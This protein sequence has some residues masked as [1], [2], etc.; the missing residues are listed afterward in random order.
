MHPGMGYYLEM[1]PYYRALPEEKLRQSPALMQAMSILCA[2]GMD[3]QGSERWYETLRDFAA[4]S[5]GGDAR[6]AK[7]RL[8]WLDVA[9]PQRGVESLVELFPKIFALLTA[10]EIRLPPFSVTSTLPSLMNGG[11]DFSPWSKRDS[12]L[13]ATLRLPVEA[14]LG[15]DGVGLADCAMAE[16]RFEKGEDIRDR[17][18]K[19]LADLERIR[20]DGTPDMEFAVVGLLAR[21]QMD[22]GHTQDAEESLH[23]LRR[24]LVQAKE[25][26]FL[27]NLDA[28][29][30]RVQLLQADDEAAAVWYRDK[31]PRDPQCIQTLNRY[32]Y[33]TQ[34][35]VQLVM[36]DPQGALFTLAPLE[37]YCQACH[38]YIDGIQL[39][40]LRAIAEQRL[41]DEQWREH[42]YAALDR[43]QEFGFVRTIS[44]YGAAVLPLLSRCRWQ[45]DASFLAR[46]LAATRKQAACYPNFLSP[47][48]RLD[49][50][51]SEA[52]LQVL[53]LLCA[54]KSNAEICEMLHIRLSTVK[55]HVSHILRKLGIT[56]RSQVKDAARRLHLVDT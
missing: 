27:P 6:E 53:R 10:R 1:E 13:Y 35:M 47:M 55:T 12:L 15:R 43:A 46:L 19:L 16:S 36:G 45:G 29:L 41:G 3:Y 23:S 40:V 44:Q 18:M 54:G 2:M 31:A 9:L 22:A 25:H 8:A 26:R 30:C 33:L 24:R 37:P 20:R 38:R 39:N 32:Q 11:K 50:P 34:A 49:A 56:R 52:E 51:L 28:M 14:V 7:G 21:V 5:R 48:Q 42:L 17:A 4:R